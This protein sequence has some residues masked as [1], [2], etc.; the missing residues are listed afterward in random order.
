MAT[1]QASKVIPPIRKE[2][3]VND[4]SQLLEMVGTFAKIRYLLYKYVL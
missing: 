2:F 1:E 3:Q 4:S